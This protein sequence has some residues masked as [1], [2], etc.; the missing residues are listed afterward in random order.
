MNI[1]PENLSQQLDF[2]FVKQSVANL[3]SNVRA[4]KQA[5]RFRT[6]EDTGELKAE[7]QKTDEVL[8]SL[9]REGSFP[10]A[11]FEPLEEFLGRLKVSGHILELEHFAQIRSATKV[12]HELYQFLKK[13]KPELPGVYAHIEAHEPQPYLIE[14]INQRIDE[15]SQLRSNASPELA[16]IRKKLVSS[17]ASAQ[18]IFDRALKKYRDK[19][20]LADFN[21]SISESRR[22]LAIQSAYKGQVQGIFH[23]SSSK[24]S[25]VFIEP[26]ETVEINNQVAQ[27]MDDEQQEIRRILRELTATIQPYYQWLSDTTAHLDKLDLLRA[28]GIYAL[29][30]EACLP[31]ISE[32]KHF[33]KE[34]YNPVLRYFNS[35][36][37]KPTVPVDI[38]LYDQTRIV[39]ISGPNAGGK[40]L[41]LKTVG[42]LQYMLQ[43]GLLIP[44][45]PSSHFRLYE[46]LYGDI[47]DAQSIENELSTY[48]SKL[49][50]MEYFLRNAHENTLLLI[51]EFGS[52]SDPDLGSALAQVFLEKLNSFQVTGVFTT[53]FNAIKALASTL[54]GVENAAML[55][56]R[57]TFKP[58]YRL[59]V[60]NPGSSY[61]FEVAEQSAIGK[62]IIE[63]AR[64]KVNSATLDVDQL[65]VEIQDERNALERKRKKQ[66]R[67]LGELRKLQKEQKEK[68]AQLEEKL[69]KQTKLNETNDRLL[70]W[71]QRFQKL[72]DS[73]M[74]QKT[75]KDKK[76]VVARFIGILNQRSSEV[77]KEEKQAD[78][79]QQKGQSKKLQ[80][81]LKEELGEGDEVKIL[82]SGVKG[83]IIGRKGDKYSIALGGTMTAVLNRDQF[84]RADAQLEDKP[85]RK[86][87]KKSFAGKQQNK[88]SNKSQNPGNK[89]S[90]S[91]A[92]GNNKPDSEANP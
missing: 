90:N 80:K 56:D 15:H 53:H 83:S 61:T 3:C 26:G 52:G 7:L 59:K 41:A 12:Y 50:K 13:R 70:Y 36:K 20:Y 74:D 22:V 29:K 85:R 92:G 25:I 35:Q 78:K 44:V 28:K 30:E 27:L 46:D 73:W 45:H 33:L 64:Q 72:V 68:I 62:H 1:Y 37:N 39:V 38:D 47:G 11:A 24:Q 84:V 82:S 17:R 75:N 8:M 76:E 9:Q 77:E 23:G 65:L 43:C 87:R 14:E 10:S 5:Q 34:A 18:R 40:S 32:K 55:F 86:K 66:E 21:E 89:G 16:Q 58:Q 67:D 63:E 49:Q 2:D 79:A 42:L 51:D 88:G 81:L 31:R 91:K 57:K 19:G 48:S 4:K 71:G 54:D 6:I 60:G 69:E